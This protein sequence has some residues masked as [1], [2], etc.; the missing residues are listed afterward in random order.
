MPS[1]VDIK[2]EHIKKLAKFMM[3]TEQAIFGRAPAVFMKVISSNPGYVFFND[4]G[5]VIGG[6]G[7][8]ISHPHYGVAWGCVGDELRES[9]VFFAKNF[10][11]LLE[12]DCREHEIEKVRTLV[13]EGFDEG[14]KF[15]EWLG[16]V[17]D[18]KKRIFGFGDQVFVNY[19]KTCNG[20]RGRD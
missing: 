1:V 15:A 14:K 11:K 9:P 19:I 13:V 2:P 10:K 20:H 3:P 4:E 5:K 8:I 16:F 7:I 17:Q 6:G 18:G 12:L